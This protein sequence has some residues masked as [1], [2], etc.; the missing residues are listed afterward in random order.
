LT[1]AGARDP[2]PIVFKPPVASAQLKSATLLAGLSAP[3]ETVV[4]EAE[5]SR[6]HTEKMLSH[7]GADIRVEPAG[8]QGHGKA[9]R[10]ALTG[11]PELTPR[12]VAVPADPSSAAFPLVAAL[13]VPGSEIVVEG[14]MMNPLRA[15]LFATLIEMGAR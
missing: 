2:A 1:L 9:R 12:P 14:V 8:G 10:I 5:P 13:I 4:I 7:F 6:D 3:G 11:Q 15:G